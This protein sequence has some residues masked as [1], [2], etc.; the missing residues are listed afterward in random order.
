MTKCSYRLMVRIHPSQGC[1]TDST[2]VESAYKII[3]DKICIKCNVKQSIDKFYR[4]KTK[5]D[6]HC[7]TCK[8]CAAAYRLCNKEK[9]SEYRLSHKKEKK[10]HHRVY[11]KNRAKSDYSF[12]L[13][14]NIST[15]LRNSIRRNGFS[16]N[17]KTK[18][19]LDC[20]FEEF[21]IHIEK[22][23]EPWMNWNN[24]GKYNGTLNYGWDIDHIIPLCKAKTEEEL[25]KLNHHT[26]LRPL[27]SKINRD[28]KRGN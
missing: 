24:Y 14:R 10:E 5:K 20:S 28:I 19:I 27:C 8:D 1:D 17:S 23:L 3:M 26:N 18:D 25:I 7:N 2:S 9:A 15:L 21:K 13:K 22:Q 11:M 6:G 16:K 4:D 12:R